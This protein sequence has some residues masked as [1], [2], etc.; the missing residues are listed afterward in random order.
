MSNLKETKGFAEL[1]G[2][3]GGLDRVKQAIEKGEKINR[4]SDDDTIKRLYFT[5]KT[6]TDNVHF[7]QLTHFKNN[8][9][10]YISKFDGE[11]TETLKIEWENRNR[12]LEDGWRII[13][14]TVKATGDENV[15]Y[16]TSFD[17]IDYIL[18]HFND[19][20]SV[21]INASITNSGSD[22]RLFKNYE[23]KKVLALKN[24]I[25]FN[26]EKFE[27][28]ADFTEE[29]VFNNC[30]DD[31]NGLI[32][33]GYFVDFRQNTA[34]VQYVVKNEDHNVA[35]YF[36]KDVKYGDLL[37]VSGI[38]NNRVTFKLVD[39]E[40]TDN[41]K[42]VVG[43]QT[44]SAKQRENRFKQRE[45]ESEDRSIQII[46]VDEIMAKKYTKEDIETTSDSVMP[47]NKEE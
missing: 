29:F 2:I 47:W 15:R 30:Y 28:Q 10:A 25:D 6:N 19:G 42:A 4:Y 1:K 41:Q 36:R 21:Y 39:A 31:V 12:Q 22:E 40:P 44:V 5:V 23:L 8:Q 11:K 13:G 37:K 33:N 45:I 46:S 35:E 3:I 43:R 18:E 17:A 24:P 34:P 20:D 26:D 16:L 32:I 7:L 27:E 38:I 9:Q 14:V